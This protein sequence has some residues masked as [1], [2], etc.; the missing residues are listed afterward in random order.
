MS[1][2]T[3]DDRHE[4]DV[5]GVALSVEGKDGEQQTVAV[6][7]RPPADADAVMDLMERMDELFAEENPRVADA[8]LA[9]LILAMGNSLRQAPEWP[10]RAR[11]DSFGRLCASLVEDAKAHMDEDAE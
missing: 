2:N 6:P 7:I 4:E 5:P 1:D 8:T 3:H 11:L 9:A 10:L